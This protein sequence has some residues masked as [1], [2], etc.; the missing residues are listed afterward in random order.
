M[1]TLA[2]SKRVL[3]AQKQRKRRARRTVIA[4]IAS[5]LTVVTVLVIVAIATN[6]SSGPAAKPDAVPPAVLADLTGVPA[7]TATAIGSGSSTNPPRPVS[8]ALRTSGGKPEVLYIGSEY[9]PFCAAQR[10]PLIQ[11]LSR[12]GHFTGLRTMRSAA[13]DVHPNTPT[14][15]FH[16][17]SYSSEY[18]TFT[19]RELYTNSRNGSNYAPLDKMS[20]EEAALLQQ[21]GGSFPL[22][23]IG[24]RF[25]QVGASYD[26]NLLHGLDWVQIAAALADQKSSI[27]RGIDGSANVLTAALCTLTN[28]QPLQVCSAPAVKGGSRG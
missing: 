12:F 20:S 1:P 2:P 21:Y 25:V 24:G 10:W 15:T 18:L 4:A 27:A 16:R 17:A 26:P 19:A 11:A 3:A 23:D 6:G 14:F 7:A 22:L 8:E 28:G 9:C 13:D 5:L